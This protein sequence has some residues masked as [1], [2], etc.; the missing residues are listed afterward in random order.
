MLHW[1]AQLWG[2]GAPGH[3]CE[4]GTRAQLW[5]GGA[6]LGGIRAQL[7][8]GGAV[9]GGHQGTAV[10]WG[11]T[12]AQLWG[13]GSSGR[14]SGH[15]WEEGKHWGGG[16]MAMGLALAAAPSSGALNHFHPGPRAEPQ[17]LQEST[18]ARAPL[19]PQPARQLCTG[20]LRSGGGRCLGAGRGRAT[21]A[22]RLAQGRRG[23]DKDGAARRRSGP[24][25]SAGAWAGGSGAVVTRRRGAALGWD[26]KGQERPRLCCPL[27]R[28]APRRRDGVR[29][30]RLHA[31]RA[32]RAQ[33]RL[34]GQCG[35]GGWS[36]GG[37][38]L[39]GGCG[40]PWWMPFPGAGLGGP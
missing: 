23:A 17:E 12:R 22:R 32:L 30:L 20:A 19:R 38:G 35:E 29:R 6:V 24:A 28:G 9:L 3:S 15:A 16:G 39:A 27:R 10:R 31:Q 37:S 21:H 26:L 7:W 40:G 25:P 2:G 18:R 13:G 36:L 11:G 14:P 33:R 8:G 5:G 1:G 34:R 4:M